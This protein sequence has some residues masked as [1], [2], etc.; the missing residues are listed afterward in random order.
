MLLLAL[1]A[2]VVSFIMARLIP[3]LPL[4]VTATAIIT[5]LLFLIYFMCSVAFRGH[6]DPH[7]AEAYLLIPIVFTIVTAPLVGLSS[8]GIG[9][10]ANRYFYARAD[11]D[12]SVDTRTLTQ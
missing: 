12:D 8:L 9:R 7:L 11:G 10:I 5:D 1:V 4:A 6:A 3:T 2:G